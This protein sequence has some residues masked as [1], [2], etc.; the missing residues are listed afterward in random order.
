[1]IIV[2]AAVEGVAECVTVHAQDPV[3]C[4]FVVLHGFTQSTGIS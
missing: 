2:H 1:M 3:G 4:W